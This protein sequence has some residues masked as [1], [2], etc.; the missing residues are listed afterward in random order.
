[1][2]WLA[3]YPRSGNTFIRNILFQVYGLESSVHHNLPDRKSPEDFHRYPV[4]KTHLPPHELPTGHQDE[5]SV[6]IIRDGRDA[7]VSEAWHRKNFKNS[8]SKVKLNMLEAIFAAEGSH[9][10]GWS[11]N[12]A[13]WVKKADV[14]LRFE[15]LIADPLAEVQK[16]G[17]V[18]QLPAAKPE[19]LPTFEQQKTGTPKYGRANDLGHNE[20]FFRSGK[21]GNWQEEMPEWVHQIFWRYHGEVMEALGYHMDGSLTHHFDMENRK[22]N[23]QQLTPSHPRR[24][25]M[26]NMRLLMTK[27]GLA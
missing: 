25:P 8:K 5:P 20:Q 13:A 27:F 26:E 7:I 11:S 4:V 12:V 23:I 2:I 16:I 9:F 14:V 17:R 3:S 22:R 6:Y 21:R 18:L 24:R 10:G 19:N 1:M 15:D